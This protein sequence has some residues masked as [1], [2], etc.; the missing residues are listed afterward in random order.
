ME[1]T[2]TER[3]AMDLLAEKACEASDFL[4]LIANENRLLILCHLAG[5]GEMS[6]TALVDAVGL[7]QS[8][9]SQHLARLRE[10]GLVAARRDGQSIQYRVGDPRALRVLETLKRIFCP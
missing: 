7:S 1:G 8:A 3:P 4:K 6:V 2:T 9:M 10:D 5:Q